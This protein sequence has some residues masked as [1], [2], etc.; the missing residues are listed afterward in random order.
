MPKPLEA[1]CFG[2]MRGLKIIA[3]WGWIGALLG[4]L[5]PAVAQ[6]LLTNGDFDSGDT[7]FTKAG[8][9]GGAVYTGTL[10]QLQYT[11][12]NSPAVANTANPAYGPNAAHT[13]GAGAKV[14]VTKGANANGTA[15]VVWSQTITGISA[16]RYT[17]SGYA[18]SASSANAP[19]FKLTVAQ[20]TAT[21]GSFTTINS[22]N[23]TPPTNTS[24]SNN[25]GFFAYGFNISGYT[26]S[27]VF[28]LTMTTTTTANTTTRANAIAWDDF[29]LTAPEPSTWAAV[30][31]LSLVA[32]DLVLRRFRRARACR[33]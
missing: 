6:N 2:R 25:W 8:M 13:T 1:L 27:L 12:T 21:S 18:A 17:F 3:R 10:A 24:A 16:G 20:G 4:I 11:V 31:F 28:T 26:G 19:T 5:Y 30:G 29:V 9:T 7:G 22:G 33:R 14:Y 15:T 23:F 32:G